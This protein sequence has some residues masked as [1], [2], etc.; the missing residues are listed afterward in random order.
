MSVILDYQMFM[1]LTYDLVPLPL[2]PQV[3]GS[4]DIE[5]SCTLR[6]FFVPLSY[7]KA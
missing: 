1:P 4:L 7:G 5:N 3:G 6:L 2:K